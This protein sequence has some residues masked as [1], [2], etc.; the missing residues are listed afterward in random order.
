MLIT[1]PT[2]EEESVSSGRL[3]IVIDSEEEM[4]YIHKPGI[5]FLLLIE[6]ICIIIIINLI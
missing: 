4:C 5:Y 2:D 1:D 6:C 3:S